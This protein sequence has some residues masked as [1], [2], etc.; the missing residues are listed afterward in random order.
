L[1]EL[2]R[3]RGVHELNLDA[4]GDGIYGLDREGNTTFCDTVVLVYKTWVNLTRYARIIPDT[5]PLY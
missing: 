4:T 5:R 1:E 3:L 2:K